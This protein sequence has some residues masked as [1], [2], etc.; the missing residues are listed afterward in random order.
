MF[1]LSLRPGELSCPFWLFERLIPSVYYTQHGLHMTRSQPAGDLR[2]MYW[3]RRMRPKSSLAH[4]NALG[5]R[6]SD[7]RNGSAHLCEKWLFFLPQSISELSSHSKFY[8]SKS[9]LKVAQ[10]PDNLKDSFKERFHIGALEEWLLSVLK[11]KKK[12]NISFFQSLFSYFYSNELIDHSEYLVSL[13]GK[14]SIQNRPQ[15]ASRSDNS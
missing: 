9:I 5:A 14:F 10:R 11:L 8:N 4:W 3:S 7:F 1:L 6:K 2:N 12:R 13:I 15:V